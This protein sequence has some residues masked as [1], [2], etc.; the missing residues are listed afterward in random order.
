M[1]NRWATGSL[2]VCRLLG[3]AAPRLRKAT[4]RKRGNGPRLGSVEVGRAAWKRTAQA[5]AA[6]KISP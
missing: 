3:G 5:Q 6:Q 4:Q 2:G 1:P